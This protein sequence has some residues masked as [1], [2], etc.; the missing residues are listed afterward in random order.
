LG[1][2]GNRF[3]GARSNDVASALSALRAEID[4]PI[5]GLDDFQIV[6]DDENRSSRVDQ[7]PKRS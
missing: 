1:Q 6:L 3:R 5:C 2:L 4:Y 7:A